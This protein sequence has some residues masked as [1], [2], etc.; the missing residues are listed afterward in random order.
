[1][2]GPNIVDKFCRVS[3]F[4]NEPLDDGRP[5]KKVYTYTKTPMK[6]PPVKIMVKRDTNDEAPDEKV[7][8]FKQQWTTMK[9]VRKL[10]ILENEEKDAMHQD[11]VEFNAEV[12][13]VRMK[14]YV[15]VPH[16]GQSPHS[17]SYAANYNEEENKGWVKPLFSSIVYRLPV[18]FV[19]TTTSAE[20]Y[21]IH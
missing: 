1:M 11:N 6:P 5:P 3:S 9:S 14:R 7:S 16:S 19:F 15:R 13:L 2:L 21:A 17:V 20:T 4:Q 8:L 18:E 10:S 12:P